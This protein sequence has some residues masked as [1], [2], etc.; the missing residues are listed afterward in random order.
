MNADTSN[1]A[2][3][4]PAAKATKLKASCDFCAL[5]KIKCDRGQPQCRRCTKNGVM[6]HYSE[7]RRIGKARQ[8]YAASRAP[9]GATMQGT[10][11][12][13]EPKSKN[14]ATAETHRTTPNSKNQIHGDGDGDGDDRCGSFDYATPL[15]LFDDFLS[16]KPELIAS[17]FGYT[18]RPARTQ[19][20]CSGSENVVV[21]FLSLE[22]PG[23]FLANNNLGGGTADLGAG[24]M[25]TNMQDSDLVGEQRIWDTPVVSGPS[26]S[27]GHTTTD[28]ISHVSAVLQTLHVTRACVRSESP[29]AKPILTL[30]VALQN[31]RMATDTVREIL[32]CP[33]SHRMSV[34][35]LL[36]LITHQVME[37]YRTVLTQHQHQ[38]APPDSDYIL[39]V[40]DIPLSIGGYLLDDNM[41]TQVVVQVIRSELEKISSLLDAFARYAETMRNQPE[42]AVLGTY[43]EALRAG[44][45]DLSHSLDERRVDA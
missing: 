41:R 45:N 43:V 27:A 6:C 29:P 1:N 12:Q 28:C 42:E 9:G 24:D 3:S 17:S 31:N 39:P 23:S 5:S 10:P 33:C 36:V 21:P 11:P 7:T 35:L 8:I 32:D 37:S 38:S 25:N 16:Q 18:T 44:L 13:G 20:Y 30:D 19:P 34:A 22:S 4:H 26:S 2:N 40:L 15:N 14:F